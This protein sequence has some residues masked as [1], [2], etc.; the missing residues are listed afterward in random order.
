M[1]TS[2]DLGRE[3]SAYE[4]LRPTEFYDTDQGIKATLAH[5]IETSPIKYAIIRT[6]TNRFKDLT[7]QAPAVDYNIDT[8][9][10]KSVRKEIRDSPIRYA[11]VFN[12]T[13]R[14]MKDTHSDAPDVVYDTD[15]LR[16]STLGRYVAEDTPIKYANVH[17]NAQ[18]F[19]KKSS[20]AAPDLMYE[21]DQ[22]MVKTL[23]RSMK[24]SAIRYSTMR[25]KCQRFRDEAT[26]TSSDL[27]PGSY[28]VPG[29]EVTRYDRKQ[30][31]LSS[32]ASSVPRLHEKRDPTKNLGSTYTQARDTVHWESKSFK[33]SRSALDRM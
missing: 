28:D 23:G 32:F 25:S 15:R 10:K 22:G 7:P 9:Y 21:T 1:Q 8:G 13:K 11:A 20:S 26:P 27:G 4:E 14:W 18:R 6:S 30:Q 19:S 33:I 3:A 12:N 2:Q 17:S 16:L 31:P 24:E 29:P 5:R